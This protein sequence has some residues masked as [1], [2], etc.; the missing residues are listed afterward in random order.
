[1]P[2][3]SSTYPKTAP[4]WRIGIR[5]VLLCATLFFA[6][7]TAFAQK[8]APVPPTPAKKVAE[9]RLLLAHYMPWFASKPV[10]GAW[11]WHW[12]MGKLDPE[13]E[14][15][16]RRDA[17][18]HYYP[19]VGLYDSGDLDALQYQ[20]M[21]WKLSGIDGVIIDWYGRDDFYDYAQMHRNVERLVPLL[22]QA[23][24]K[25]AVC[26]ETQILPNEI[27]KGKLVASDAVKHGQD[28]MRWLQTHF[29]ASPAYVKL[30]NRPL[31]L[32][33]GDTYYKDAQWAEVFAPLSIKPLL[34][35]ENDR[36]RAP[37]ASFGAFDWPAAQ[38]EQDAF[39]ARAA[40]WPLFIPD[41]FPRFDDFYKGAGVQPGYPKIDDNSGQ[42]FRKTLTRALQSKA[43][44]VQIATWNDW[45]EGT[46]IEPS[47]QFGYRDLEATQTLRKTHWKTPQMYSAADLRLP[48]IWYNAR[49]KWASDAKASKELGQ[50][51]PLVANG[52]IEQARRILARYNK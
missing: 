3:V 27:G 46:Q 20:V 47:A 5:F 41:A 13:K 26:Y 8:T 51:F 39:Y 30:D 2:N 25:F 43:S 40:G 35:V 6:S 12:T 45:G 14:K 1:M 15:N 50:V 33:F 44:I 10:S 19:L 24:L 22:E 48:V 34:V 17:A 7:S 42:T 32:V 37:S 31:F 9:P 38:K 16:G 49:K 18:S 11:G 28:E 52:K 21:L 4:C 29:F 23:N 36:S